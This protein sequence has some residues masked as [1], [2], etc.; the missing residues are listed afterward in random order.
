ME[1]L[2]VGGVAHM[3]KIIER[4][5]FPGFC[6]AL[7]AEMSEIGFGIRIESSELKTYSPT[8]SVYSLDIFRES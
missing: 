3:Y 5:A 7:V 1:R 2:K 4:E 6:D 8:M